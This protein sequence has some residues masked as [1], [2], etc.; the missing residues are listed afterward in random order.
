MIRRL[1]GVQVD[2]VWLGVIPDGVGHL[3]QFV[4]LVHFFLKFIKTIHKLL[5]PRSQHKT[6]LGLFSRQVSE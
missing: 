1:I 2:L 3:L 5:F 6:S 4:I